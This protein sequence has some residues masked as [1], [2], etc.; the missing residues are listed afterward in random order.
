MISDVIPLDRTM[1]NIRGVQLPMH[2]SV[3]AM[4]ILMKLFFPP[5]QP[6]RSTENRLILSYSGVCSLCV[7]LT[8]RFC[9]SSS[10]SSSSLF[11]RFILFLSFCFGCACR[12]R[13]PQRI[14][15]DGTPRKVK[16]FNSFNL[17][18]EALKF[19]IR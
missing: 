6:L 8:F 16:L 17:I 12:N 15:D 3:C 10:S 13:K 18:L 5:S 4:L 2:V 1:P 9:F 14:A 7:L 19:L 11:V